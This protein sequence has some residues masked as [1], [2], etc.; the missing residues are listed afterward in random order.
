MEGQQELLLSV[1][2]C[3]LPERAAAF[4]RL[5]NQLDTQ[6]MWVGENKS[7][8]IV[9]RDPLDPTGTKR[10]RNVQKAKGLFVVHF[11]DDDHPNVNYIST[12]IAA[13]ESCPDADCIGINGYIT[14][15]G[16]NMKKWEISKEFGS[17]YERDNVYYRTPN[18]ISPVRREI[19]LMCPFPDIT[20]GED[21]AYS[22]AIF[23]Y[24]K[25]EVRVLEDVYHYDKWS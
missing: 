24:L 10:N 7:E 4:A 20:S 18:H 25:K 2:I 23:P 6:R 3:T 13:I 12:I 9:D 11:D 5:Y 17:W 14:T 1:L 15:N 16:A 22:T 19:A 8:I 21:A